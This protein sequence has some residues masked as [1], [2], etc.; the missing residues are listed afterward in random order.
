M[1]SSHG[2]NGFPAPEATERA[3]RLQEG[4]CGDLLGVFRRPDD[5]IRGSECDGLVHAYELLVCGGV[6]ALCPRDELGFFEWPA[7]HCAF[8]T[9]SA[10]EV[11]AEERSSV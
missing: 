7:H 1:A 6:A 9:A 2:R 8:Y 3:V 4:I 11:P 5:E 10:A